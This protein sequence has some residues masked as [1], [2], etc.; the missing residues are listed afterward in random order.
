M[1][2]VENTSRQESHDVMGVRLFA[3][4]KELCQR[5]F[6]YARLVLDKDFEDDVVFVEC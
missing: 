6:I 4:E 5:E 3:A 2:R 1:Q